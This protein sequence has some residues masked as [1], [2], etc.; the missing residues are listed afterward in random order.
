MNNTKKLYKSN[1]KVLS[2]VLAGV[3][4]YFDVDP[5]IVRLGYI[6]LAVVTGIF[7]AIIGYVI[8]AVIIPQK[9]HVH[10]MDYTEVKHEP[11]A[12]EKKEEAKPESTQN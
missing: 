6:V 12:E 7:P 4:E 8:A 9:P 10:H 2:G 3:A 11:K 5:T 1:D